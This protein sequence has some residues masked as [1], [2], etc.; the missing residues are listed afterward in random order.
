M[1]DFKEARV[2]VLVFQGGRMGTSAANALFRMTTSCAVRLLDL[3]A[4]FL[5]AEPENVTRL[6]RSDFALSA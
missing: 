1:L 5:I 6:A 2:S 4:L 3:I